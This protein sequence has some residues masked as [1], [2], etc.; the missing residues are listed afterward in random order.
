MGITAI[1]TILSFGLG[2]QNYMDTLADEAGADKLYIQARGIGAPGTD[3]NFRLTKDD[4]DF[5]GKTRGVED[6]TA[7]Y[8]DAGSV[9]FKDQIIYAYVSGLDTDDLEFFEESF[10]F[11]IEKGRQL[12]DDDIGKVALGYRYGQDDKAFEKAVRTGDDIKVNGVD[13]EVVGFYEEVGNP[14]DDV[15]VYLT[16]A[17]FEELYDIKDEYGFAMIKAEKGVDT[18]ELAEKITIKLRKHK[19]QDEGQ[20]DFFVQTFEDVL[21]TF[22]VIINVL[23]G[24][25]ILI[26][27]I[28]VIVA[29]VN[30]MNTMYTAVLE[31]TKEIGIMKAIGSTNKRILMI[32]ML[33]SGLLGLI[34]GVV[35]IGLGYLIASTGGKFAAESGFALLQPAFPWYLTAGCLLFGF[36]VGAVSGLLPS[37]QASKQKPV[38]A[39]RYE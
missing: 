24:V 33:E 32:F 38:D 19:D 18:G 21:A 30:I 14:A 36:F 6:I 25:L 23:N 3:D 10:S 35:G 27:L 2:L 9:E 8:M 28:S 4:I 26:A 15:N 13:F 31:R 34:G 22:G 16:Q 39:L 11:K 20:E 12:R 37:I 7:I 17:Q 5:V 1:Y 29:S